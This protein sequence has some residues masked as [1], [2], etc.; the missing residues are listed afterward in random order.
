MLFRSERGREREGL[1]EGLEKGLE[2]GLKKGREEGREEGRVETT[3]K[4]FRDKLHLSEDKII[5]EL[6][7]E[8]GLSREEAEESLKKY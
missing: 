8:C 5:E 3:I 6:M 2:K 1:E 4:I 7:D